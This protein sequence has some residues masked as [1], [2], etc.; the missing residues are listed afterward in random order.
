MEIMIKNTAMKGWR[1]IVLGM[2]T[3]ALGETATCTPVNEGMT[4]IPTKLRHTRNNDLISLYE[5]H[6]GSQI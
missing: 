2:K 4:R 3:V 5:K 6:H 1:R